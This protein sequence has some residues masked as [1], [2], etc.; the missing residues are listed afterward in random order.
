MKIMIK[1]LQFALL[2]FVFTWCLSV[3]AQVEDL[4]TLRAG[5][6]KIK[7]TTRAGIERTGTGFIVKITDDAGYIVTASH[8]IE[9]VEE[10][11]VE[12]FTRPNILVPSSVFTRD[13]TSDLAILLVRDKLDHGEVA[14][15][16]GSS[17][18]LEA[19]TEIAV[20]GCPR[21]GTEWSITTGNITGEGVDL[22][23][24]VSIDEGSSGSPVI[25]DKQVV[26]VVTSAQDS[27]GRA[28]PVE[29]LRR[30]LKSKRLELPVP[31][32][33]GRTSDFPSG[34]ERVYIAEFDKWPTPDTEHGSITL[35]FGNSYVMRP[36]SNIWIGPGRMMEITP[37]LNQDF[38][39]DMKFR[40]ESRSP[41]AVISFELSGAA[42]DADDVNV[43]LE[44]WNE[45]SATYSITKGRVKSGALPVPHAIPEES[46]AERAQLSAG[47]KSHDWSKGGKI[48]MKREGG[49]MQLFVND[50][51]VNDFR[52]SVFP[53]QLISV[54]A[55]FNS[56]V[57]ITSIEARA[58]P[59][60]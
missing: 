8:V 26:G 58:R 57:V 54:G 53:V 22:P 15:T 16:L 52:V 19:P 56:T 20:I 10:P 3:S 5:V 40:V 48:T 60:K 21:S 25:K 30:L 44:L 27:F 59:K 9:D 42:T 51:Y 41:S 13:E 43:Y 28:T 29:T 11:K 55:A 6:V 50:I 45:N 24:N 38:V 49:E 35:G 34:S 32:K 23:L 14:L 47:I 12:F 33:L 17:E 7:A 18:E 46:I 39:L 36:K 2:I 37:P 1:F 4:R 31:T